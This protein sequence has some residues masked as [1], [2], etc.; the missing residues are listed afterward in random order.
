VTTGE[1]T[2]ENTIVKAGDRTGVATVERTNGIIESWL[3]D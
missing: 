2:V 1:T 3:A